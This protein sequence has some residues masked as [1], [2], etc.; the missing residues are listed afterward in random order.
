MSR[1]S[2][3][4]ITLVTALSLVSPGLLGAEERPVLELSLEEAVQ[5]AMENNVDI[6]VERFS[7]EDAASSPSPRPTSSRGA[8]RW[9]PTRRS[10]TSA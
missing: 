1:Q 6:A 2:R 3:T 5:R 4:L 10:S 9:R 8:R 7:P